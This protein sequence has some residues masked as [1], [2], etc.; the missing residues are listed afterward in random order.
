[1]CE[2]SPVHRPTSAFLQNLPRVVSFGKSGLS[3]RALNLSYYLKC[4]MF[5]Y[6]PLQA[7]VVNFFHKTRCL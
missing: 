2:A 1:M 5:P 6:E 4:S 3:V 7:N